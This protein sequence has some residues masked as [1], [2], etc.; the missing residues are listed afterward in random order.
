MHYPQL[1]ELFGEVRRF[2]GVNGAGREAHPCRDQDG[3][4]GKVTCWGQG[5]PGNNTGPVPSAM[6]GGGEGAAEV[7]P[8][9]SA[10]PGLGQAPSP[11]PSQ[12]CAPHRALPSSG[13]LTAP[14]NI[15]HHFLQ[16]SKGG[17]Q[18]HRLWSQSGLDS[19]PGAPRLLAVAS[20][21]PSLSLRILSWKAGTAHDPWERNLTQSLV[22]SRCTTAVRRGQAAEDPKAS[23]TWG[24]PTDRGFSSKG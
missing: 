3:R 12:V 24:A 13:L 18:P 22:H 15:Q 1:L 14:A 9:K 23:P 7:S 21:D 5:D 16:L 2:Q 10:K 17:D 8:A 19:D 11:L 4:E 20:G 6:E